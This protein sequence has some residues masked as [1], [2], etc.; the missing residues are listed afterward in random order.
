MLGFSPKSASVNHFSKKTRDLQDPAL[1][2]F[3]ACQL[4]SQSLLE[5]STPCQGG[6]CLKTLGCS[7]AGGDGFIPTILPLNNLSLLQAYPALTD[8]QAGLGGAINL[9]SWLLDLQRP[10]LTRSHLKSWLGSTE[11]KMGDEASEV[12]DRGVTDS[13]GTLPLLLKMLQGNAAAGVCQDLCFQGAGW[14]WLV[15]CP[16]NTPG[17][18]TGPQSIPEFPWLAAKLV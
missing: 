16:S 4:P 15:Q 17:K 11:K 7:L 8:H 12:T 1:V 10:P 2:E 18:N 13:E 6:S 9:S 5:S 3:G 14:I